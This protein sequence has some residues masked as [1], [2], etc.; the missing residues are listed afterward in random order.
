M[1]SPIL[2]ADD[3]FIILT[4]NQ[5]RKVLYYRGFLEL[6]YILIPIVLYLPVEA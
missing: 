6:S 4:D 5:L 3:P 2:K 1:V